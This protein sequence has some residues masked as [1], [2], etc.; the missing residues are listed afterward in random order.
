MVFASGV[1]ALSFDDT[2]QSQTKALENAYL[3]TGR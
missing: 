2:S 3:A 1:I